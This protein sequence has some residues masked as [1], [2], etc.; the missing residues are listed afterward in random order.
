MVALCIG[1]AIDDRVPLVL[2]VDNMNAGVSGR[3]SLNGAAEPTLTFR[4][5]QGGGPYIPKTLLFGNARM[6]VMPETLKQGVDNDWLPAPPPA[7]PLAS[8]PHFRTWALRF[9]LA[10]VVFCTTIP[11]ENNRLPLAARVYSSLKGP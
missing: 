10:Q 3:E 7:N 8:T 4:L 5:R 2:R 1:I 11:N 9:D 6:W